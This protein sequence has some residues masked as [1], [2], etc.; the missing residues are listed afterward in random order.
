MKKRE[1]LH[2][3]FG[4]TFFGA[5]I[6]ESTFV[7]LNL[8]NCE[9]ATA[10]HGITYV[11]LRFNRTRQ[12]RSRTIRRTIET[13]NESFPD[14][15]VVLTGPEHT[16]GVHTFSVDDPWKKSYIYKT[17]VA[18]RQKLLLKQPSTY[19]CWSRPTPLELRERRVREEQAEIRAQLQ[20]EAAPAPSP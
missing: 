7:D 20:L 9:Q 16:N 13:Y 10:T 6:P 18:E 4:L 5:H 15:K 1:C 12:T 17:I 11:I 14:R 19:R 8:V 3:V 2:S